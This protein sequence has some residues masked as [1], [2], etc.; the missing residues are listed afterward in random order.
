MKQNFKIVL[1]LLGLL[2][3]R[4]VFI[5][6]NSFTG[7]E[8]SNAQS[9]AVAE[10]VKP[11]LDPQNQ[12]SQRSFGAMIRKSAHVL[13]YALLGVVAMTALLF[14]AKQRGVAVLSH[15][16]TALFFVLL[17]AVLDEY[18]QSFTGRTSAVKDVWIDRGGG[19]LG[20][21]LTW[22]FHALMQRVR[23]ARTP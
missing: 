19:T 2:L 13:E 7:S 14:F 8:Q 4:V 5:W 20:I 1:P 11:V 9:N 23:R 18:I 10:V 21:L 6:G 3:L 12:I 22:G 17:V 15:L 16:P